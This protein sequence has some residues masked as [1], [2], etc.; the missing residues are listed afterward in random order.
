MHIQL[1]PLTEG[2]LRE[3]LGGR[4]GYFKIFYDTEDCGCNGML[5][6]RIVD[7]P[8]PTDIR[9]QEEPFVFLC[10]RQQEQQF[11]P[12]LRIEADPGYPSF[13]VT[14]DAALYGSNIRIQ[15]KRK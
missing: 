7:E 2:R 9:F 6:I 15:D 14:S 1:D 13:K 12:V 11:D 4:P 8:S 5:V 3:S 10:D